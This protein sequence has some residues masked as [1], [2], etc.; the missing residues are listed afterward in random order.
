VSLEAEQCHSLHSLHGQVEIAWMVIGLTLN[1]N[2][3]MSPLDDLLA[4]YQDNSHGWDP[5][6]P[7]IHPVAR[8]VSITWHPPTLSYRQQS[9]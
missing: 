3:L 7:H 1:S 8:G 6:I 2:I 9:R 4:S 5:T